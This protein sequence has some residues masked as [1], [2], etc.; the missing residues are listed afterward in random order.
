MLKI[1]NQEIQQVDGRKNEK[2]AWSIANSRLV[3]DLYRDNPEL[4]DKNHKN[5]GN[6]AVTKKVFVPIL[7]KLPQ[8]SITHI[9]VSCVCSLVC[10]IIWSKLPKYAPSC[11]L[12]VQIDPRTCSGS[13]TLRVYRPLLFGERNRPAMFLLQKLYEKEFL[14]SMLNFSKLL[15]DN[16]TPT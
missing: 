12:V 4:Y 3:I 11:V 14:N 15:W 2:S 13:K 10:T 16:S 8:K 5:Y 9:K 6:K 1:Q 7:A